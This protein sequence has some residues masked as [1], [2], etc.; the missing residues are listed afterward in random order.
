MTD[1]WYVPSAQLRSTDARHFARQA[2][3]YGW[4]VEA[5]QEH[6]WSGELGTYDETVVTEIDA[7]GCVYT[8]YA[9][10]LAVDKDGI[11]A[12]F[13]WRLRSRTPDGQ[14]ISATGVNVHINEAHNCLTTLGRID[15]R[16]A[17]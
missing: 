10:W 12:Q 5:C 17:V 7:D 14:A 9:F 2:R 4:R 11:V 15:L 3:R 6:A 13:H 8:L 16:E 1:A